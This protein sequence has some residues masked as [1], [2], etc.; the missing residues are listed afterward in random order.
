MS[1]EVFCKHF[2]TVTLCLFPYV[3][4]YAYYFWEE[5][6]PTY[7][8]R[9]VIGSWDERPAQSSSNYKE[10]YLQNPQVSRNVDLK[11]SFVKK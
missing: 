10:T 6:Y 5:D 2:T 9:M 7:T 1:F 8:K 3:P 11:K 4:W